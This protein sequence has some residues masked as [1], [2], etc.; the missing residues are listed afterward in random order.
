MNQGQFA[1]I[2]ALLTEIRDLLKAQKPT[3]IAVPNDANAVDIMEEL[4]QVAAQP[5]KRRGRQKKVSE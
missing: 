4:N 3:I 1:A 5:A 2:T